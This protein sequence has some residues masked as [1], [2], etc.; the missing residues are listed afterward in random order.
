MHRSAP[1]LVAQA[2]NI[3]APYHPL[4]DQQYF[5]TWVDSV[6]SRHRWLNIILHLEFCLTRHLNKKFPTTTIHES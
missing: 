6:D 1:R 3:T 4:Y 2:K 5:I